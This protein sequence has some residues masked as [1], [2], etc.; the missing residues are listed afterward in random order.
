V[1]LDYQKSR[2]TAAL[3][4][5]PTVGGWY[6]RDL[7]LYAAGDAAMCGHVFLYG[8]AGKAIMACNLALVA[9]VFLHTHGLEHSSNLVFHFTPC[10][11]RG[12]PGLPSEITYI[13]RQTSPSTIDLER[14]HN[15][16]KPEV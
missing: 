2:K 7:S 16:L 1:A 9:S 6:F 5:L 3:R 13:V 8:A 15:A 4:A 11:R 10:R 14:Q 12:L